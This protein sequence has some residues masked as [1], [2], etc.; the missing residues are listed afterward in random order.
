M[1]AFAAAAL[2]VAIGPSLGTA[3]TPQ[4]SVAVE[5]FTCEDAIR[6]IPPGAKPP[7]VLQLVNEHHLNFEENFL[8]VVR[9]NSPQRIS[10]MYLV[11]LDDESSAM[12]DALFGLPCLRL[13]GITSVRS[14]WVIR[15]KILVCLLERGHDVLLSDNDALWL[16][17]PI[18]ELHAIEGDILLQRGVIPAQYGD[19]VYGTTMCMGFGLF[20][21]GGEG[22][23]RFLEVVNDAVDECGDDQVSVNKAAFMLGLKW[24]YNTSRSDMRNTESTR[25]GRGTLTGLP[26]DFT[27]TLLPHNGYT[28]NCQKTPIS[29]ETVVVHCFPRKSRMRAMKKANLW[30]AN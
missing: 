9:K 27:V 5:D 16:S 29:S 6:A 30:L 26:G 23:Q 2:G 8:L 12:L 1:V 19:P 15:T 18:P 21:A 25:I 28:R 3:P 20:R 10:S 4:E 17:D 14:I 22:M 11:C 13:D 7:L 24:D